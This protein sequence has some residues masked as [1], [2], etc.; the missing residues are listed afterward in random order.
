[1]KL[2]IACSLG[3]GSLLATSNMQ[4]S[5]NISN[6]ETLRSVMRT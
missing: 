6:I 1:M 3:I 5:T 2:L 4:G